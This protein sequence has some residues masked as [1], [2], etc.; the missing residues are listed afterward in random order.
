[1]A[2]SSVIDRYPE[3]SK[4]WASTTLS[5]STLVDTVATT[6]AWPTASHAWLSACSPSNLIRRFP[7]RWNRT[8]HT[9]SA[10]KHLRCRAMAPPPLK[11]RTL[12]ADPVFEA[13]AKA[14]LR[15]HYPVG[16]ALPPERELSVR[17]RVSRLIARQAMHRLRDI[18]LVRGAQG[19]KNHVLDPDDANDPRL[20]ALMMRL[21]PERTDERDVTE[22]QMLAGAMLLEL[23][24]MRMTRVEA[25]ELDAMLIAAERPDGTLKQPSLGSFEARFWT[26]VARCSRNKILL[27]EVRWWFDVIGQQ[28]D[29]RRRYYDR[30]ELRLVVYRMVVDSLKDG[31]Q[32][33]AQLYTNAIRP[34]LQDR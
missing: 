1:M 11:R 14:I 23:A 28:P 30:P 2:S 34:I 32:Q 18:G 6:T 19:G 25:D 10:V 29:R 16:S 13:L 27:R 22:R 17:F 15:G 24:Q 33:A 21:A 26:F 12:A 20:V 5:T 7:P 4:N 31:T 3:S 8:T 9:A